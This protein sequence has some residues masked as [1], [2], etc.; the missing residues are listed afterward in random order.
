MEARS[1]PCEDEEITSHDKPGGD[2]AQDDL[3]PMS[4]SKYRKVQHDIAK[5]YSRVLDKAIHKAKT[6]SK[7]HR[8]RLK[9]DNWRAE[10]WKEDLE[11]AT[12]EHDKAY[13]EAL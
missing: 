7:W 3:L 5:C 6:R 4:L 11:L 13:E 1:P 8:E 10:R 2:D 12:H 9:Q